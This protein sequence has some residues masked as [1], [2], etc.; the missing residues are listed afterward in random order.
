[1]QVLWSSLRA[2]GRSD[3]A[4]RLLHNYLRSERRER[5]SCC[6]LLRLATVDDPEWTRPDES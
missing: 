1:M 5:R 2:V 6:Y 3:D 4:S